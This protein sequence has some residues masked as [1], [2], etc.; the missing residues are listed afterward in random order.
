MQEGS[1]G[2]HLEREATSGA[3]SWR[4]RP[5]PPREG[6]PTTVCS[7]R[8][9]PYQGVSCYRLP[10]SSASDKPWVLPEH[11]CQSLPSGGRCL[12]FMCLGFSSFTGGGSLAGLAPGT[13]T[14]YFIFTP[15]MV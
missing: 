3:S 4:S 5:A 13:H 14:H 1:V 8:C 6:F 10:L 9:P 15:S 7:G 12:S 2:G 11:L